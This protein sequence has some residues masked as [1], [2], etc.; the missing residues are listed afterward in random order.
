MGCMRLMA[1]EACI[2]LLPSASTVRPH[3]LSSASRAALPWTT[4]LRAADGH[5][6]SMHS[7]H[8]WLHLHASMHSHA[9]TGVRM[10]LEYMDNARKGPVPWAHCATCFIEAS[11]NWCSP[12]A[13]QVLQLLVQFFVSIQL[14]P[15]NREWR[16][17]LIGSFLVVL[18]CGA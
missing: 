11:C 6:H 15:S 1:Q 3:V 4:R 9:S 12:V 14:I 10:P 8:S 13:D 2:A 17:S 7:Q 16:H 5:A 18:A